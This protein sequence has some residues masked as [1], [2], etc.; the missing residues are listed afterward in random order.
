[1]AKNSGSKG[2]SLIEVLIVIFILA[3][4]V[5]TLIGI[6]VYGFNLQAKTKQTALATQVSQFEVERYRNMAFDA[7]DPQA[8]TS[9]TFV[10]LYNNDPESPYKFLFNSDNEP[11]LV[12]G[13]ETITIQDGT[14]INMDKFIKKLTVTVEWDYRTRRIADGDPM[15]KDVVTYLSVGGIN[16]R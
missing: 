15:R 16:R 8:A 2:F 4:V 11:Y 7:I 13:R 14:N 10:N 9:E 5:I 12:N 3:V 6:F 1:M